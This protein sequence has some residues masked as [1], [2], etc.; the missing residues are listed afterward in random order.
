MEGIKD[1][2][3]HKPPK[4]K[5]TAI[6]LCAGQLGDLM[7]ANDPQLMAK[8]ENYVTKLMESIAHKS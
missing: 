1:W 4:L 2:F 5:N 7:L 6:S 3:K 8:I